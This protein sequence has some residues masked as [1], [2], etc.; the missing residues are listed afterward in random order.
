MQV[1]TLMSLAADK[2]TELAARRGFLDHH[3]TARARPGAPSR[4]TLRAERCTLHDL[5]CTLA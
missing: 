2:L 4:T 1:D 5:R 3:G